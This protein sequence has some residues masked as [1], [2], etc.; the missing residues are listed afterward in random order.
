MAS[1]SVQS[2]EV[3]LSASG[4]LL[5]SIT[6]TFPASTLSLPIGLNVIYDPLTLALSKTSHP[7]ILNLAQ[8]PEPST[9]NIRAPPLARVS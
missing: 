2:I 1:T 5:I 7:P 6:N 9:N 8:F 4:V 3:P